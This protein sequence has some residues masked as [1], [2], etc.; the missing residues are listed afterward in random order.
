MNTGSPVCETLEESV[1]LLGGGDFVGKSGP[2]GFLA[3]NHFLTLSAVKMQ[4]D[5][6]VCCSCHYAFP[7]MKDC[8]PQTVSQN[9]AFH[10]SVA[11]VGMLFHSSEKVSK[12]KIGVE[13]KNLKYCSTDLA[14][15][16]SA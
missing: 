10:P 4:C 11:F 12:A 14:S 16:P 1:E 8:I 9:K 2:Q 7:A 13:S 6:P 5:Q 3:W 15:L